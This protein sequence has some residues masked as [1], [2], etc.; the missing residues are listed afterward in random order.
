MTAHAY[1]GR[2]PVLYV[3]N[4]AGKVI[5]QQR[6]GALSYRFDYAQ[7]C[8][9][10]TDSLGRTSVYHFEG[11]AGLRRVVKVQ[12]PDDSITQSRFD[13]SGRVTASIDALG[14]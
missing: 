14:R 4:E 13:A 5:E 1:K 10:V 9:T 11:Q 3:Y 6:Q 8:T 2:P 12:H 7:D